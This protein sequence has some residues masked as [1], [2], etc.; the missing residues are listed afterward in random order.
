MDVLDVQ[1]AAFPTLDD[2]RLAALGQC[3]LTARKAFVDGEAL[4]RA[5]DRNAKFFIVI[6]GG[7]VIVD[8]TGN[9]PKTITSHSRGQF[10]GDVSQI[11]GRPAIVSGYARGE[12]QV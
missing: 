5:G 2:D 10:S 3:T 4:F 6:S 8:E 12:T 1:A 7:I 9:E 11:T